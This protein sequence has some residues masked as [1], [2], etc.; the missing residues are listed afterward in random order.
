MTLENNSK[1]EKPLVIYKTQG[2][3]FIIPPGYIV[4]KSTTTITTIP[5]KDGNNKNP[6]ATSSK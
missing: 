4:P 3:N 5:L 6:H 2:P 1:M